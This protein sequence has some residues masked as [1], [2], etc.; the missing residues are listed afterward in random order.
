MRLD[1]ILFLQANV[2]ADDVEKLFAPENQADLQRIVKCNVIPLKISKDTI[3]NGSEV[4]LKSLEPSCS[5]KL[6][7]LYVDTRVPERETLTTSNGTS[8]SVVG[9]VGDM[10][11]RR[12][13]PSQQSTSRETGRMVRVKS[14]RFWVD[15]K[16]VDVRRGRDG[17][18]IQVGLRSRDLKMPPDLQ[19]KYGKYSGSRGRI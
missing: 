4:E 2:L 9:S 12:C 15:N 7:G 11:V 3:P 14:E 1:Y 10:P 8:C 6:K 18:N 13:T 17:K 5:Y 16:E 19:L